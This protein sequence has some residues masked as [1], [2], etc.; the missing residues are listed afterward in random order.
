MGVVV[1]GAAAV[2]SVYLPL[3]LPRAAS[4]PLALRSTIDF[5]SL[6]IFSLTITTWGKLDI[7]NVPDMA[8]M[9]V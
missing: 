5:L 2:S 8:C 7:S 6:S 1:A 3:S 9:K 4:L